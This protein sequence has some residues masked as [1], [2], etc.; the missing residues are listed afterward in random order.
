MCYGM[1]CPYELPSGECYA[2]MVA[3]G[4]KPPRDASCYIEYEEYEEEED[5]HI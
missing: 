2:S 5:E 3:S 1:Y 4:D